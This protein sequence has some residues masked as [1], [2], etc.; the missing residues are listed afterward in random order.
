MTIRKLNGPLMLNR[1]V[2]KGRKCVSRR[3]KP[4][5]RGFPPSS[6]KSPGGAKESDL[7]LPPLRGLGYVSG[8]PTGG[9]RLRPNDLKP[10]RGSRISLFIRQT[11]PTHLSQA[12]SLAAPKS[13][14]RQ[15]PDGAGHKHD[16]E[17]DQRRRT[18]AHQYFLV[19][20]AQQIGAVKCPHRQNRQPD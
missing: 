11:R 13:R 14:L 1:S 10:L 9:L 12:T 19:A 4:P 7:S 2:P 8:S 16:A 3:R 17:I 5:V 18:K 6:L 20:A 15:Q